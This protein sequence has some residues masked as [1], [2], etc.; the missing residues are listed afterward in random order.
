MNYKW[1][2]LL[3]EFDVAEGEIKFLG[4]TIEYQSQQAPAIGNII[5]DQR[6]AGGIIEAT[7]VF[8]ET[9]ERSAAEL[10]LSYDPQSHGFLVA[11]LG[12]V[13]GTMFD[14]RDFRPGAPDLPWRVH[15]A[16]GNRENLEHGRAYNLRA[17][18]A[19][20]LVTLHVD[21]VHVLSAT[22][23]YSLKETQVGLWFMAD[24]VVHAS[25]F[26]VKGRKPRAFIIMA[27]SS[28]FNEIYMDVI[29]RACED[30]GV[31]AVRADEIYGPGLIIND[32]VQEILRSPLIIADITPQNANV[33]FEVGYAFALNKPIIL[34]AERTTNLPFDISAFRVLFYEDSIAGKSKIE[35]G[36][37][38][39]IKAILGVS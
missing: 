10:I 17:T 15:A 1:M 5:S 29:K 3:G 14:I 38:K 13:P 31:E 21:G 28:P 27:F 32:V 19:G 37:Q 23:P 8:D 6:F 35:Q 39:H 34:L 12:G 26:Q 16:A 30:N 20:S 2:P 22:L 11:G 7:L 9:K 25:S 36:L 4:K 33:F 24:H 18:V